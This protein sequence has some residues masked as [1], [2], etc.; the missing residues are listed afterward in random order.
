MIEPSAVFFLRRSHVMFEKVDARAIQPI[1]DLVT[2]LDA[3]LGRVEDEATGADGMIA[4][5]R[6]PSKP[7][8][9]VELIVQRRWII[10]MLAILLFKL[11]HNDGARGRTSVTLRALLV[12]VKGCPL[13]WDSSGLGFIQVF[14]W[15]P[16]DA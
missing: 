13:P 10:T 2:V 14:F 5:L 16:C 9:C 4:S 15:T 7:F 3:G 1:R 8:C 11:R 6:L 12:S